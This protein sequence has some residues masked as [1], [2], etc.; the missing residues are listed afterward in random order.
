MSELGD[1]VTPT[2]ELPPMRLPP[3][4]LKDEV[5][6]QADNMESAKVSHTDILFRCR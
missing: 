5:C 4:L 3:R 6:F 2:V 1:Q